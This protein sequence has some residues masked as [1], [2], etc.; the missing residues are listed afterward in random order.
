MWIAHHRTYSHNVR[1]SGSR[2]VDGVISTAIGAPL[3]PSDSKRLA[4][5]NPARIN[6]T[7]AQSSENEAVET[8]KSR[9]SPK[10][11]HQHQI[12]AGL[13]SLRVQNPAP[14]GRQRKHIASPA[15]F[16]AFGN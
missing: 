6:Q 12:A 16:V 8:A 10:I 1:G 5:T 3:T 11:F 2:S 9:H 13:L 15:T 14:V 4:R 7:P